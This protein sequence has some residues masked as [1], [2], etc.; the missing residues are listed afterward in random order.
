MIQQ[1]SKKLVIYNEVGDACVA[2]WED[3][4]T[5]RCPNWSGGLRAK[6]SEDGKRLDWHGGT[7]WIKAG[8]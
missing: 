8:E 7:V 3:Q 4:H 1:S 5:I 6:V 2:E